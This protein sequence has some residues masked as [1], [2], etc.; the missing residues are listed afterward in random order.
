MRLT[1][2]LLTLCALS[3]SGCFSKEC[4][5]MYAPDNL[6]IT[7]EP[8]LSDAGAWTVELSGDLSATC[9]VTL[10]LADDGAPDCDLEGVDLLISDDSSSIE[11]V[12]F[13]ALAPDAVTLTVSLEGEELLSEDLAPT[14]ESDEPNGE[15]CGDRRSAE[16]IVSTATE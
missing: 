14:Y 4:N 15:G 9:T 5:Q 12:S 16:V 6:Q 10:P 2:A 1:P 7:F 13:F 8:S 3:L 11:G